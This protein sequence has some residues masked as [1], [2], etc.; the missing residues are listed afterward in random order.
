M[1]LNPKLDRGVSYKDL[2]P[3]DLVFF[4]FT[5]G[6]ISHVGIYLGGNQ[7]IGA[8]TSGLRIVTINQYWISH[9]VTAR[10]VY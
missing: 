4:S 2:R 8:E 9:Y 10:R 1:C 6:S 7:Y 3:G 5:N